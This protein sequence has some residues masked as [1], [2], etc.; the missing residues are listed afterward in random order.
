MAAISQKSDKQLS[1]T[2]FAGRFIGGKVAG[3]TAMSAFYGAVATF[4]TASTGTAISTLSGA[5]ATNATLY[6]IG[7]LVGGGVAAGATV[8][9]FGAT[10]IG[11]GA[12]LWWSHKF[13]SKPRQLRDLELPEKR[14]LCSCDILLRALEPEA[15]DIANTSRRTPSGAERMLLSQDGIQPIIAAIS[16]SLLSKEREELLKKRL[17]RKYVKTLRAEY[18][19]LVEWQRAFARTYTKKSSR[20]AK[21]R[22]S[23]GSVLLQLWRIFF[24]KK[25]QEVDIERT[26]SGSVFLT[27]VHL[28]KDPSGPMSSEHEFVLDAIRRS[29]TELCD[30]TVEE[31]SNFLSLLSSDELTEVTKVTN[32][33]FKAHVKNKYRSSNENIVGEEQDLDQGDLTFVLEGGEIERVRH[34]ASI[35]TDEIHEHF[36]LHPAVELRAS[37]A[38][39]PQQLIAILEGLGSTELKEFVLNQDV[40]RR[41]AELKALG[42]ISSISDELISSAYVVA[43]TTVHSIIVKK[44]SPEAALND[45]LIISGIITS[46]N[47]ISNTLGDSLGLP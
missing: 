3:V 23:N 32:D 26:A 39:K 8:M 43:A 9:T 41:L 20:R 40:I 16:S 31:V 12:M 4:G 1:K 38:L 15:N 24:S 44:Q 14:I 5:A 47:I 46:G 36:Q 30:A 21:P 2:R 45:A 42:F 7:G 6:W 25:E 33:L 28:I 27:F 34:V 29:R 18:E 13:G 11:A 10:V 37:E 17:K 22:I 35:N 19:K